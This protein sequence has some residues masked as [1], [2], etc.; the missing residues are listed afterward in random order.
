MLEILS[1][2]APVFL[3]IGLGYAAVR[4]SV[5]ARGDM[6]ILGA[7]VINFALPAMLFKALAQR[8]FD[9][10][11]NPGYLLAYALGSIIALTCGLLLARYVLKRDFQSSVVVGMGSAMSNSAFIGL[12]VIMPLLGPLTSVALVLSMLVENLLMLPLIFTLADS[13]GADGHSKGQVLRGT[14]VRL[15]KNPLVIAIVLGFAV[16][17]SGLHIP[18]PLFKAVDMLSLASTAVALFTIGGNLSGI[19]VQGM[20]RDLGL[21]AF[22]KLLLHPA[23]V[24]AAVSFVPGITPELQAAAVLFASLPMFSIYGILGQKYG[25]ES[26][27]S[28]AL[29]V[30]TSASFVT[31]GF[32]IWVM[33]AGTRIPALF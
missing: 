6:R 10:I 7:F 28:G 23:A 19:V 30:A 14:L 26:M 29:L 9:D 20:R 15:V 27:C 18:Q 17:L 22:G 16:S 32:V 5:F 11:M 12:P 1:V 31:I 21:I 13:G 3:L 8:A 2:T 33:K 25:L 24:W 4:A